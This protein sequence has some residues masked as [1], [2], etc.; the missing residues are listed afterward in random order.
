MPLLKYCDSNMALAN[1]R[2]TDW[3]FNA[4]LQPGYN[5]DKIQKTFKVWWIILTTLLT[6]AILF[7][8]YYYR[9]NIISGLTTLKNRYLPIYTFMTNPS[10]FRKMVVPERHQLFTNNKR[11]IKSIISANVQLLPANKESREWIEDHKSIPLTATSNQKVSVQQKS[12]ELMLVTKSENRKLNPVASTISH[13]K[14]IEGR[15]RESPI[16]N[17]KVTRYEWNTLPRTLKKKSKEISLLDIPK[18]PPRKAKLSL[19]VEKDNQKDIELDKDSSLKF[20]TLPYRKPSADSFRSTKSF[21]KFSSLK[22]T[23]K[24][25]QSFLNKLKKPFKTLRQSIQ[26]MFDDGIEKDDDFKYIQ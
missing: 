2:D 25:D 5:C 26:N 19:T 15:S 22:R 1:K 11:N 16:D 24:E 23:F 14:Q 20:S 21:P 4:C 17:L 18:R 3:L 9:A 6:L 10:S 7:S 13:L 8:F 12:G